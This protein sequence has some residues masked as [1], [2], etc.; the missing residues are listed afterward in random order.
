[1]KKISDEVVEAMAR[2]LS[3]AY[4]AMVATPEGG[5]REVARAAISLGARPPS[6]DRRARLAEL[7]GADSTNYLGT[8]LTLRELMELHTAEK[9]A[10]SWALQPREEQRRRLDAIVRLSAELARL[11]ETTQFSM[12]LAEMAI[13]AVIEGDWK[14]VEEWA[15]Y[16]AF[17]GE[18]AGLREKYAPVFNV[19]R[20]LLCQALRA[21]KDLFA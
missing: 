17:G 13:E 18:D 7:L 2:E 12:R 6:E 10:A 20:E 5:W 21:G 16:F 19:F 8:G 15:D 3:R 14:M 1:M 4:D 9:L 11:R